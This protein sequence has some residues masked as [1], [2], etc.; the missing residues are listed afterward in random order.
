MSNSYP[1]TDKNDPSYEV[2]WICSAGVYR[3]F[4]TDKGSICPNIYLSDP[5]PINNLKFLNE[6]LSI[7]FEDDLEPARYPEEN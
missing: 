3:L 6:Q 1:L 7:T 4:I 5:I 2:E